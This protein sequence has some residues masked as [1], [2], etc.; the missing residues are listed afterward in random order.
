[1]A[2]QDLFPLSTPRVDV[3]REQEL[4]LAAQAHAGADWALAALVA[5]YQPVVVRYLV[6]L[7]G[8]PQ[9]ATQ[10]SVG[11]FTR[12]EQRVLGPHG[13]EHLRLWL[14]RASTEAGLD[15]LRRPGASRAPRLAGAPSNTM[16]LLAAQTSSAP[17]GKRLRGRLA[18]L[19]G[20]T[21]RQVR[22]LVWNRASA[23]DDQGVAEADSEQDDAVWAATEGP[24]D[25]ELDG[26]DP[27]D[28]LRHRLVRAVLAELPYG[29]AQCLALHLVAGLNQAEVADALGIRPSAARRRIVQGLQLFG[30]RYEAALASMGIPPEAAYADFT[31]DQPS[32]PAED[33]PTSPVPTIDALPPE[34]P[35]LAPAPGG[36]ARRED[37]VI[38]PARGTSASRGEPVTPE[39]EE[40]EPSYLPQRSAGEDSH[41]P[42]DSVTLLTDVAPAPHAQ[43]VVTAVVEHM[44]AA[45]Q[46]EATPETLESLAEVLRVAKTMPLPPL[47]DAATLRAPSTIP[48]PPLDG[49]VL[50]RSRMTMP[51][52]PLD[53]DEAPILIRLANAADLQPDVAELEGLL[54]GPVVEADAAVH[55]PEQSAVPSPDDESMLDDR[56]LAELETGPLHTAPSESEEAATST[57][58]VALPEAEVP[59]EAAGVPEAIAGVPEAISALTAI[60][61]V[62]TPRLEAAVIVPVLT[63]DSVRPVPAAIVPVL[64]PAPITAKRIGTRHR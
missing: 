37:V 29:D 60:V 61:P 40:T 53:V 17:A 1:M 13:G 52:P 31:S 62:L 25:Q 32:A 11:I 44:P 27:R 47:E 41:P 23:T 19:T 49:E 36:R 22:Q 14:L 4:H 54:V 45:D 24:I 18:E 5:R 38:S 26:L 35:T 64:T 30:R 20:T 42:L 55:V 21:R 12:M 28:A 63:P 33:E 15:A 56:S 6:R 58:E 10:L 8:N 57:V 51:L 7:T 59:D 50:P 46:S 9:R 43:S 2:W 3:E 39:P 48:L 16:G 34:A